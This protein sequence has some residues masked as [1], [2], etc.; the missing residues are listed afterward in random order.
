VKLL[1]DTNVLLWLL[2][3]DDRLGQ[4]ARRAIQDAQEI[5]V[6]EASLWEISIKISIGKLAP[7]PKLLETIR[8]LGFRRLSFSDPYLHA[9]ESL[10]LIHR[11]PFDRM[12]VAQ[13]KVEKSAL[14]T[15]DSF[16]SSYD[17]KVVG[18]S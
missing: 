5:A 9:Y 3:D 12:L 2:G 15:S 16:L 14:V 4:S 7:I 6:S 13:A 1:L 17:V 18:T 10:P 11:D 8:S